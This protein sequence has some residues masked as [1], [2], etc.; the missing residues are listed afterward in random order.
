MAFFLTFLLYV[1]LFFVHIFV[2]QEGWG[3]EVKNWFVIVGGFLFTMI[4]AGFI[5]LAKRIR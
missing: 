5:E 2:M 3:L 1:L 4:V